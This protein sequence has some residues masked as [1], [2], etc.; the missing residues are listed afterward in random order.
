LKI[1]SY[2]RIFEI[3]FESISLT[4]FKILLKSI[5]HNTGNYLYNSTSHIHCRMADF[6]LIGE[7][8]K[9]APNISKSVKFEVSGPQR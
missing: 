8:D 9:R 7:K 5:L 4:V 6:F 3:L 1:L 2:I